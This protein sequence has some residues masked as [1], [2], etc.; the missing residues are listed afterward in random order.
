MPAISMSPSFM[1]GD[2]KRPEVNGVEEAS[3]GDEEKEKEEE[4]DDDEYV[5]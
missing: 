4:D 5:E 1:D 2:T 3:E